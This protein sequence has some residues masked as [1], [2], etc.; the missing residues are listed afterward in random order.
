MMDKYEILMTT[1]AATISLNCVTTLP[2]CFLLPIQ[3]WP[4]SVLCVRKSE[5]CLFCRRETNV[6][7][8]SRGDPVGFVK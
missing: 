2:M 7:M 5:L 3:R 6:W 4:I 1:D 8:R